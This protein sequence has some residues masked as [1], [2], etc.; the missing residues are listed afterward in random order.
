MLSIKYHT[1]HDF[2]AL[3]A[4]RDLVAR[5]DQGFFISNLPFAHDAN[6]GKLVSR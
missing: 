5:G 6:V 3:P 1:L 2:T 4:L